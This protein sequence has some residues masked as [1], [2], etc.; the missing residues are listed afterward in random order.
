MIGTR[1]K[2][3]RID[4]VLALGFSSIRLAKVPDST[5]N[6]YHVTCSSQ[7]SGNVL[8]K[9]WTFQGDVKND[10]IGFLFHQVEQNIIIFVLNTNYESR[11]IPYNMQQLLH[12]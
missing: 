9:L 10:L 3:L 7:H 4:L 12:N 1:K 5:D 11:P 6:A 2:S 8:L